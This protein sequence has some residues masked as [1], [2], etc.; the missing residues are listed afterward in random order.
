[1]FRLSL[2]AH[3]T[4]TH[5]YVFSVTLFLT[6]IINNFW[7]EGVG[8]SGE[9]EREMKSKMIL[10]QQNNKKARVRG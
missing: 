9:G 10:L 3:Y 4:D 1:M 8:E 5:P 7:K 2:Q 6:C